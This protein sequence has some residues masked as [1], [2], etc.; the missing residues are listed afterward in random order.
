MRVQHSHAEVVHTKV[1][2]EIEVMKRCHSNFSCRGS[3]AT[4]LHH[5][6]GSYRIT[7]TD[8]NSR[9]SSCLTN[10]L[11]SG[12]SVMLEMVKRTSNTKMIS[13]MLT[14]HGGEIFIHT[15]SCCRWDR[16]S[17]SDKIFLLFMKVEVRM[18]KSKSLQ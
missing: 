7:P 12:R 18:I 15:L 13:H 1:I 2:T 14:S 10:F 5:C 4:E 17:L 9:Q 11:L 8:V 16:L 6:S 3:T